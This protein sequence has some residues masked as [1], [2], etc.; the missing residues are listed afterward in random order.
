MF[1][2]LNVDTTKILIECQSIGHL[3]FIS[4]SNTSCIFFVFFYQLNCDSFCRRDKSISMIAFSIFIVNRR[5]KKKGSHLS[6]LVYIDYLQAICRSIR[7]I[8][9]YPSITDVSSFIFN[10]MKRRE[11]LFLSIGRYR[12]SNETSVRRFS[13]YFSF[14]EHL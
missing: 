12:C 1:F 9:I 14:L 3:G 13:R 6:F 11:K 8:I 2:N 5:Q 7:R 4:K 10:R